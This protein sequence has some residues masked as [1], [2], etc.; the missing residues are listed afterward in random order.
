MA[1][2]PR[3][4]PCARDFTP[5]LYGPQPTSLGALL[6]FG[7]AVGTSLGDWDSVSGPRGKTEWMLRFSLTVSYLRLAEQLEDM[8]VR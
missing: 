1:V 8:L 6:G 3:A 4:L 5:K 2:S 7:A